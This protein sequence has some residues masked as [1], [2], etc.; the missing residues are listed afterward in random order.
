[1]SDGMKMHARRGHITNESWTAMRKGERAASHRGSGGTMAVS[2]EAGFFQQRAGGLVFH[3]RHNKLPQKQWLRTTLVCCLAAPWVVDVPRRS[4]GLK[5]R[6]Q[7]SWAPVR[8]SKG[9]STSSPFPASGSFLCPRSRP[10]RP[11]SKPQGCVSDHGREGSLL[12][13]TPSD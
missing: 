4:P 1:M 8:G 9:D 3:S 12:P 11:S 7:H 6:W 2:R 5:S 13:R 10:L